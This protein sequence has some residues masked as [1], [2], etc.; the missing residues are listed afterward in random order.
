MTRKLWTKTQIDAVVQAAVRMRNNSQVHMSSGDALEKAQK[1]ILPEHQ[2]LAP[3]SVKQ[4]NNW[5]QTLFVTALKAGLIPKTHIRVSRLERAYPELKI[6]PLQVKEPEPE[7]PQ[8][9]DAGIRA[10]LADFEDR[11]VDKIAK[12]VLELLNA[13]VSVGTECKIVLPQI[14]EPK[15]FRIVVVGLIGTQNSTMRQWLVNHDGNKDGRFKLIC[16]PSDSSHN[17]IRAACKASVLAIVMTKFISHSTE[18]VVKKSA[19]KEFQRCNGGTS[20]L[21]RTISMFIQ[22]FGED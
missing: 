13:D 1:Q 22:S 14:V 8:T 21:G 15:E 4:P 9:L 19:A 20:D 7:K 11:L 17:Q 2:W 6:P 3:T 10:F 5:S 18:A 16:L 12:R